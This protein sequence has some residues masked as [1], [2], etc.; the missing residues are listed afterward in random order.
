MSERTGIY[1][2]VMRNDKFCDMRSEKMKDKLY[3]PMYKSEVRKKFSKMYRKNG[4][5]NDFLESKI[6]FLN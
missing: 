2:V 4:W 5:R 1:E 6:F 3:N